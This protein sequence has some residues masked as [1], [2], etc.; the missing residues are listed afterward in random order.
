MTPVLFGISN[1]DTVKKAKKWLDQHTINYTFHDVRKDGISQATVNEWLR[2][3]D[4]GILVN[5]RSTTWKQLSDTDKAR[6]D[7]DTAALLLEHPTLI[8]RPVLATATSLLVGF[9]ETH[10]QQ[11]ISNEEL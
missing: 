6:A 10:Y 11:L 8:K 2:Q 7:E 3:A 4:A 5:K 1:C 9:N